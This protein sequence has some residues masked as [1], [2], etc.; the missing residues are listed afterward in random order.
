MNDALE[1]DLEHSYPKLARRVIE[2]LMH[3]Y[4]RHG[5]EAPSIVHLPR[6]S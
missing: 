3:E 5:V 2:L 1:W 4:D 6:S